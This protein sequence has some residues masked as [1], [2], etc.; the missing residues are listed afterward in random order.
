MRFRLVA[1]ATVSLLLSLPAGASRPLVSSTIMA[2]VVKVAQCET[3]GKWNSRGPVYQGGLGWLHSTWL[4][5]R[6]P[7]FPLDMSNATPQQQAWAMDRF[8]SQTLHY[9]PHQNYPMTCGGGY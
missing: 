9:W 8:V 4:D 3:H 6:A 2:K 1:L 7:S 5:Y